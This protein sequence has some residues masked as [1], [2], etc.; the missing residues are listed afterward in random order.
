[1][2]PDV[3]IEGQKVNIHFKSEIAMS[4]SIVL[5]RYFDTLFP[6]LNSVSKTIDDNS[7]DVLSISL[8]IGEITS[9]ESLL[10]NRE[11]WKRKH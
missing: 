2:H 6:E 10:E 11:I 9:Q 4:L 8:G 5:A 1:M 7:N 3:R